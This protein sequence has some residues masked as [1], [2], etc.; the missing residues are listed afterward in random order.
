MWDLPN[1][2]ITS[3]SLGVGPGKYKRRN[4]LVAKNVTNFIMGKPLKNQV[5]RE[6]GY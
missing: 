1:V 6:L 3:H 4:D 5:N 2:L